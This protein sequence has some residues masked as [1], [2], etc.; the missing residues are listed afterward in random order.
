MALSTTFF[1]GVLRPLFHAGKLT[2][3]GKEMGTKFHTGLHTGEETGNKAYIREQT[4]G[5]GWEQETALILSKVFFVEL[6]T[7]FGW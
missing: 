3:K 2:R 1:P 6:N 7:G 4:E 5:E